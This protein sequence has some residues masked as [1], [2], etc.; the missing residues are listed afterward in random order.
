MDFAIM[1][2]MTTE[3]KLLITADALGFLLE[4]FSR[5]LSIYWTTGDTKYGLKE[6][7]N[8]TWVV[9]YCQMYNVISAIFSERF[10]FH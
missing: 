1:E 3:V 8:K 5:T 9:E 6:D 2:S 4:R 7:Y 10:R